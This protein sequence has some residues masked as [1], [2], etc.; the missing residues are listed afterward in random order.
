[1]TDIQLSVITPVFNGKKYLESCLSNVAAQAFPGLEHLI[2]DGCSNDGSLEILKDWQ[3]RHSHIRVISEKDNGQSDAMNKGIRLAK[4]NIIGFL[5]VDDYYE[6]NV[7]P[8]IPAIFENL[9]VPSFVC[10]NLNILNA[11]GSLKHFNKPNRISLPELLSHQFEW[12]YNPSAYFYHKSLH[13]LCG[14]YNESNHYCMD[15]EFILE[16][17]Q[18]IKLKHVDELWGNFC[19]VAESKTLQRFTHRNE[20]AAAEGKALRERA[21]QKLNAEQKAELEQLLAQSKTSIS[22]PAAKPNLIRKIRQLFRV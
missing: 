4:G 13:M 3:A 17:A 6:S 21:I 22:P 8:K 15:Y 14:F 2:M 1:M 16:V 18:K 20:E 19:Q 11:D 9:P 5:N 7:L 12:P 10:G